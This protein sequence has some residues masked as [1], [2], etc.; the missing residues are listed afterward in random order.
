MRRLSV[1]SLPRHYHS[2]GTIVTQMVACEVTVQEMAKGLL[3]SRN[4]AKRELENDT[5]AGTAIA[6][7]QG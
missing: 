4:I 3:H 5:V 2:L 6:I 1:A 7:P